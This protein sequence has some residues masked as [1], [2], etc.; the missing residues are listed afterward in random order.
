MAEPL[1]FCMVT[2]FYPPY[3]FGGDAMHAY[4]LTNALARRGHS[5][6]VVHSEDTYRALGGAD[7]AGSFPHEPGVTLRP[8]R[9]AFPL[10]AAT[11]TY[12]SGRPVFYGRQLDDVFREQRFDVVHFHNVSLAG[13]PGVLRYGDGVKLYTTS[14]HWLVCPMHVL[15]RDNREPCVE[16]HCLR[17]TLAFRRP[18]Q[19]WRYTRLLERELPHVDLFLSPSRFTKRAH[20]ERGFTRPIRHLPYF[21]PPVEPA[22]PARRERP[23]FLF[24][25][26]LE[27]LKG[28]QVLVEALR[29]YREADLL[30]VGEGEYRAELE[31]LAAGLDHVHFLGRVHPS[32]LPPLYAGA[33]SLLVPSVGYEVFGIVVLEAFAQRTPAIV[34]DLGAL[35]EVIEEAGGGLVYRTPAELVDALETLRT[36]PGRRQ[37]LGDTGHDALQRLWSEDTHVESYFAALD[38]ARGLSG[39]PSSPVTKLGRP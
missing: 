10:G 26:R 32:E 23:Y 19:L 17:C 27:R 15:F 24:V 20:E 13:G 4:R 34:H 38:E 39:R 3:H 33:V 28:V 9:T 16:P 1:S 30:I 25:G 11:A 35:P 14:E 22:D 8:L 18:P 7:P 36:D 21:L 31:R 2:T 37:E 6:T 12:L 29:S 5:V